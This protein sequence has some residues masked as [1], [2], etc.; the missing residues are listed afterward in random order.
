MACECYVLLE[1]QYGT[2]YVM[3]TC[4]YAELELMYSVAP[5]EK[6]KNK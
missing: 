5:K 3:K 6:D 4:Q 1:D 2:S